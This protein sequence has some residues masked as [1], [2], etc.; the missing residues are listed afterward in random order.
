MLSLP[1]RRASSVLNYRPLKARAGSSQLPPV[2]DITAEDEDEELR[3]ALTLSL[4][5]TANGESAPVFG[6]SERQD[7]NQSWAMVPVS[8]NQTQGGQDGDHD[9][10]LR[11]AVEASM[12]MNA[13]EDHMPV[14]AKWRGASIWE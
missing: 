5:P 1:Q 11:R 12:N 10:D 4:G 7:T 2:I 9:A 14:Q 6:P 8:Q 13:V 3:K